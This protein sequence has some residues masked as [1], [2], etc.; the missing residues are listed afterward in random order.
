MS[1]R[2]EVL[3]TVAPRARRQPPSPP[4]PRRRG[5]AVARATLPPLAGGALVAVSLPP[6]GWWPAAIVGIAVL[7]RTLEGRGWGS[8]LLAGFLA[9]LGQFAIGLLWALQ[10]NTA[11]YVA[12]VIAESLFVAAACALTPPGRGRVPALAGLLTLAEMGRY[13]W[14]F[15]GM[16]LGGIA[17]GQA[18]GPLV[19][20]ARIGGPFLVAG[21]TFLAGAGLG[22]VARRPSRETLGG[23]LAA[24]LAVGAAVG[25]VFA[26]AG[27][28]PVRNIRVAIVQGG[29]QRGLS[30][31]QVPASVVYDAALAPT[32]QL[33]RG[34]EL[35]LWPEDV[36]A[37]DG[38][39]KGS[40]EAAT[41][42]GLAR[43][44]RT[45]LL[46]GV[47][48]PVGRTQFRN[49][50]VAFAPS[51]HVVA[52]FEKVHRVPFG[53]YVPLR[54]FF[55]HLANLSGVPRDAIPGTGSGMIAT[56]AG[57]LAVLVSYEVF[58]PG[59]G[60]S[61]VRA[62]GQLIVLPTNTSSYSS[63]Q[64]PTQEIAASRLQA[65]SQGRWLLQAA[66]TGFSAVISSTGDVLARSSLGSPDVIR[67]TVPLLD[68]ATPYQRFGDLP[69][70][71]LAVLAALLGW[72][73]AWPRPWA[74]RNV[75]A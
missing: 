58:F 35:V 6:L 46:V 18:A 69:V 57:R 30:Q 9:G 1:D 28:Q 40:S 17:L 47:T 31:L 60:R 5:L 29:G 27:G 11:G 55:R 45:T 24:V 32:E 37:L 4:P 48:E 73:R 56:P 20:A 52:T 54:G 26:P 8:R 25:G 72:A 22:E 59:R 41:L 15:G 16:P 43:R 38:P 2:T 50:I 39:L 64:A 75:T 42:A 49:E 12:L 7:A 3:A 65:V 61:G 19:P 63:S 62:G 10:F 66:P 70:L 68:G 14:P 34:P 51:G 44:L 21:V 33:K 13:A 53:E 23:L 74:I 67:A 36:V 71:L